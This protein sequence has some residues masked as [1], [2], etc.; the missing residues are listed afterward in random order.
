[1]QESQEAWCHVDD[2][3]I[4]HLSPDD[5]ALRAARESAREAGL[6]D[7]EVAANQGKL[8]AL[9]CQMIRAR[10]VLEFG[11]L[12]GYSTIWLARAVGDQGHVTT[13]EL[14]PTAAEVARVNFER[15][16]VS[17]RISLMEGPAADSAQQL[18]DAGAEPFD[19]VFLDADKPNN[20]R[21]LRAALN[22]TRSGS[23]II[24]DNV[25]RHG[26]VAN[27]MSDDPR[28]HGSRALIEAMGSDE[29]LEATGIQTVG[30]K[31]WDGF[32][33]ARVR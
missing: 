23:L 16:G 10:R 7:H 4:E 27:P 2:Y 17:D 1:M 11:T 19:L 3:L 31:G 18:I 22:L 32:A 9:F 14:D 24:V 8:L 29:R 30:L 21:Y 20:P 26:A 5:G 25:V 6:P 15:A 13:L 33:L 28:V 12:A